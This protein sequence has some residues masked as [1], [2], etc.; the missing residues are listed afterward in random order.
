MC[1]GMYLE[2]ASKRTV[3]KACHDKVEAKFSLLIANLSYVPDR[4]GHGKA[5]P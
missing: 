2:P 5:A 4:D 3:S 1:R